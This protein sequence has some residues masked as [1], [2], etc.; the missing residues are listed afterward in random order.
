MMG[1]ERQ[2][3]TLKRPGT[4]LPT[5]KPG[6]RVLAIRRP[7]AIYDSRCTTPA[8]ARHRRAPAWNSET[9]EGHRCGCGEARASDDSSV[10]DAVSARSSETR[11]AERRESKAAPPSVGRKCP[12]GVRHAYGM[13]GDGS[14]ATS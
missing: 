7:P 3:R 13:I 14:P 8:R 4:G 6:V 9:I 2:V 10:H 5:S 1:D 12:G 11:I